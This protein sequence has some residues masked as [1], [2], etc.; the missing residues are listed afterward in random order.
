MR[1]S[2]DEIRRLLRE[3]LPQ[4]E[5]AR[6]TGRSKST[7]SWHARRLDRPIDARC[8]RRYDWAAIQAYYDE[9]HSITECQARFGF[10]RQTWNDA[11]RSG[12]VVSRPQAMP[13]EELLARRRGRDHI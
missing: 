11:R 1:P 6:R 3:G 10:A 9:G 13:V 4:A 7:V 8:A 2:G 12:R 5:V